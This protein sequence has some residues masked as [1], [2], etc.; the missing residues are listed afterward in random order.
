MDHLLVFLKLQYPNDDVNQGNMTIFLKDYFGAYDHEIV[1]SQVVGGID[2][3]I[4][5]LKVNYM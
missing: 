2:F 3:V 4:S 5:F 1:Q